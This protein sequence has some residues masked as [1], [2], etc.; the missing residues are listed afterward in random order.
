MLYVPGNNNV[1]SLKD[2]P[3]TALHWLIFI[4]PQQACTSPT[5][6]NLSKSE[7]DVDVEQ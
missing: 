6:Q 5:Y 3:V 2:C 1:D 4:H 7:V